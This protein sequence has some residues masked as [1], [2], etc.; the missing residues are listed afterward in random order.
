MPLLAEHKVTEHEALVPVFA[1][2]ENLNGY[3]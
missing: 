2:L 3:R 1:T